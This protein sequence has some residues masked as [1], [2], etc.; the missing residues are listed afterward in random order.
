MPEPSSTRFFAYLPRV[1]SFSCGEAAGTI[2]AC[3]D[4]SS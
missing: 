2:A 4:E 3:D 1:R